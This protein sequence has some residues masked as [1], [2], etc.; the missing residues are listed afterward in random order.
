MASNSGVALAN[1]VSPSYKDVNPKYSNRWQMRHG[2]SQIPHFTMILASRSSTR[3][4]KNEA[5]NIMRNWRFIPMLF[6]NHYCKL[7]TP[8]GSE[9]IYRMTS[10][11]VDRASSLDEPLS[12]H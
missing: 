3:Y 12:C 7:T 1:P 9:G 10:D 11:E 6:C 5:P 4:Y 8:S 2:T